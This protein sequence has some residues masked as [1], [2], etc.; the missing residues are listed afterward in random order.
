[1]L[2]EKALVSCSMRRGMPALSAILSRA[3]CCPIMLPSGKV[4]ALPT[5]TSARQAASGKSMSPPFG[6]G[7]TGM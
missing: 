2:S 1:M 7:M 6:A 5:L 3:S 4:T